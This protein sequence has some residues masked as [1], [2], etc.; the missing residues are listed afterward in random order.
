MKKRVLSLLLVCSMILSMFAG[1]SVTAFA[2]DAEDAFEID[3]DGVITDYTGDGGSVVIPDTINGTIV[4][5]IGD[6]AFMYYNYNISITSITIP[7]TVDSIGM[8][9]FCLQEDLTNVTFLGT[10]TEIDSSAF[11]EEFSGT[12]HCLKS[13]EAHYTAIFNENWPDVTVEAACT[14][15]WSLPTVTKEATCT[16]DGE[17]TRTCT[18][19]S[20]MKTESIPATGHSY[21]NGVCTACGA[22]EPCTEH[23]WDEGKITTAPTCTAKGE[24]TYT[25]TVC[26]AEKTEPVDTVDHTYEDG[27][28]T[29]CGAKQSALVVLSGSG[30]Q[31]DPYQLSSA[32]DLATLSTA[33][34]NGETCEGQYFVLTDDIAV[35]GSW[36]PIGSSSSAVFSGSFD[37]SGHRVTLNSSTTYSNRG[38]FGVVKFATIENVIV[39]GTVSGGNYVGGVVGQAISSTLRNLGNEA[40]VT[41]TTGYVGGVVGYLTYDTRNGGVPCTIENCYNR[42]AV[43][44]TAKAQTVG[45]V[46]GG[47]SS[48]SSGTTTFTACYN[49]GSVTS[50]YYAGGILGSNDSG[51]KIAFSDCYDAGTLTGTGKSYV[52]SMAGFCNNLGTDPKMTNCYY[53]TGKNYY[54]YNGEQKPA[55]DQAAGNAASKA[56]E[57][58]AEEMKAAADS[59]GSSYKADSGINSGYPVLSWEKTCEHPAGSIINVAAVA[60][61]CTEQGYTAGT[62]CTLC[63]VYLTGHEPVDALGHTHTADGTVTAPTCTA[64]GYTTYTCSRCGVSYPDDFTDPTGHEIGADGKCTNPGCT[65]QDNFYLF[66]SGASKYLTVKNDSEM[67]WT[68]EQD[69]AIVRNPANKSARFTMTVNKAGTLSLNYAYYYDTFTLKSGDETLLSVAKSYSKKEASL[70]QHVEAGQ[71]LEFTVTPNSTGTY[72]YGYYFKLTKLTFDVDCDHIN[73]V[74]AARIEPTCTTGG[75]EAGKMCTDC[76]K[77]L[78]TPIA[79]TGHKVDADGLCETCGKTDTCRQSSRGRTRS[80]GRSRRCVAPPAA[81]PPACRAETRTS[82]ASCRSFPSSGCRSAR[83]FSFPAA[84]LMLADPLPEPDK[85]HRHQRKAAG[86]Q[87]QYRVTRIRQRGM[88]F[89]KF[90]HVCHTPICFSRFSSENRGC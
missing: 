46:A 15:V 78:G 56:T 50:G 66:F 18:E 25:C 90:M 31:S 84:F 33:V 89:Q 62:Q 59:L 28:C 16:E 37:G 36:S 45:G 32:A 14:H 40:D 12:V 10:C 41:G 69:G 79:P 30:T 20:A 49:T 13:D 1:L 17:Q 75:Y 87:R 52:G 8:L 88:L 70:T 73:Q 21:E 11:D 82:G 4:T 39:D 60:P 83:G 58:T 64:Q 22:K 65:Y 2:A 43:S 67:P 26:G 81:Q 29:V 23:T 80:S 35:D 77:H 48:M 27:V 38:L 3:A 42:G 76:G 19:C 74:D 7:A 61:T 34:K 53:V 5:A 85:P 86:Q 47:C 68:Y 55:T 57:M 24:K 51:K 63:N 44:C 72:D 9:A 54:I 6:Q 71:V